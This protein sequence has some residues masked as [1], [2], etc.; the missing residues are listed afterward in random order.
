[1]E[2]SSRQYTSFVTYNGQFEFLYVPFGISNSPAVFTRYIAAVLRDLI[3]DGTIIVY[4]DDIVIPAKDEMEGLEKFRVVLSRAA[5]SGLQIKWS[6]CQ[7]LQREVN[8]LGYVVCNGSIKPAE[9]KIR[10]VK[11]FPIPTDRKAVQRFLGLTSYFRKF[12]ENYAVIA[13]PLS[14][15]LRKDAPF[16][17]DDEVLVS[18]QQLREALISA[19]VLKLYDPD[20]ITELHADASKIGYGAVLLQKSSDDLQLHPVQ[21]MSRRKKDYEERYHSYELEVLAIIEALKKWRVYLL[22]I[23][24]KIVTDCNAF[25][26]TM[27]K[28]DV[29]PRI[30]RWALFMQD[31]RASSDVDQYLRKNL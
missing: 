15:L 5:A 14:D 25:K 12:I 2:E 24:F 26:M 31:F 23:P 27:N 28:K 7:I 8:F 17:I 16:V 4:M 6:K 29:P 30:S 3:Q 13:K 10:A 21:Y 20:A 18:C 1:M 19:P 9:E 11:N 22:G